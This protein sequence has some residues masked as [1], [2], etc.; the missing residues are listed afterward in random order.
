MISVMIVDHDPA[1][2]AALAVDLS[3]LGL[4][5]S[6]AT[7]GDEALAKARL[8]FPD[9]I[10]LDVHMPGMDGFEVLRKLRE[11]PATRYTPVVM[12]TGLPAVEGE[13]SAM[14]L[15]G[16][17]YITKPWNID[18]LEASVRVAIREWMAPRE[19]APGPQSSLHP[20]CL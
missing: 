1:V 3:D 5:P 2:R 12:L 19:S 8:E 18:V 9:V 11:S 20:G 4:A 10:L 14:T 17:G 13:A 6:E 16:S 7:T 15:G